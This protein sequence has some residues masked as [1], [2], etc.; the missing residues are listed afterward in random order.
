MHHLLLHICCAMSTSHQSLRNAS[1][2]GHPHMRQHVCGL[3]QRLLS[4]AHCD[5]QACLHAA[6]SLQCITNKQ[7]LQQRRVQVPDQRRTSWKCGTITAAGIL[8]VHWLPELGSWSRTSK[9]PMYK[10]AS[11]LLTA[12]IAA[13]E[14]IKIYAKYMMLML[15]WT[16]APRCEAQW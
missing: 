16:Q 1:G 9:F 11:C 14:L 4:A 5:R 6:V 7:K 13:A 10:P 3:H 12:D 8:R 15:V 2:P